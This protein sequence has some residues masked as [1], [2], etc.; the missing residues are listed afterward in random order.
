LVELKSYIAAKDALTL[1]GN[2][3]RNRVR[4]RI[5]TANGGNSKRYACKKNIE[6]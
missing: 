6:P 1:R 2:A 5:D 4:D 3:S